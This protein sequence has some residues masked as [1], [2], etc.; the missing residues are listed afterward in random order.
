[1]SSWTPEPGRHRRD[2][3][4]ESPLDAF[5]QPVLE[6][7]EPIDT[8]IPQ[9]VLPGKQ[10][11]FIRPPRFLLLLLH[12]RKSAFGL[13]VLTIIVLVAIF[14]PLIA[15]YPPTEMTDAISEGPS[16]THWFGTTQQGW[17]VFS[18]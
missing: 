14:A 11:R 18:Q 16:T 12:N 10:R 1:M 7:V 4:I 5:G 8:S 13:A 6:S 9:V 3:V 15:R 2:R 17:D